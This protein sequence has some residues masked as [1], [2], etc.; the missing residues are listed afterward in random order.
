VEKKDAAAGQ[1]VGFLANVGT[2]LTE[3]ADTR[4]WHLLPGTVSMARLR[5]P[6]GTHELTVE[7]DHGTGSERTLSLG[8]ATVAAGR[9]TFVT[10]RIWR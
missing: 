7:L 3:R 1:L 2:L 8:T 10:H 5:L 9:T 6:P 4:C